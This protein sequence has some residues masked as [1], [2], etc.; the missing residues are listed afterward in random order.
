MEENQPPPSDSSVEATTFTR[1]N[2]AGELD[3]TAQETVAGTT[4]PEALPEEDNK[5]DMQSDPFMIIVMFAISVYVFKIW[6]DDYKDAKKGDP[7]PKGFPG[8]VSCAPIAVWIA[9]IGALILVLVETGGE[10]ALGVSAQQSDITWLFLLSMIA[11]SFF[12]E[13]VFRGYLVITKKGKAMLIA[14]V[15]G[16]SFL[17]AILHP[18]LWDLELPDDVP[19]GRFWRGNWTF[20]FSVKAWFS[21]IIVFIN[22]LWFYTVRFYVWNKNWSLIPCMAAHLASNLAVFVIKLMQG[23]VVGLY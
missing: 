2:A 14:S 5:S 13:L 23:H 4:Q 17:F 3:A 18:F 7:N 10:Y 9:V 11:A 19:L 22:S 12:E 8:A 16:F 1:E 6:L 15:I 21:T 20:D